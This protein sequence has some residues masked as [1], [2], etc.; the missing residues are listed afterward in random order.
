MSGGV[1]VIVLGHKEALVSMGMKTS[2]LIL[3]WD[4]LLVFE[5]GG[6]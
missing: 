6:L 4:L 3:D 5:V 2:T 1:E